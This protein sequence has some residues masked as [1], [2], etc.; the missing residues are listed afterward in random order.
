MSTLETLARPK[1]KLEDEESLPVDK[2]LK[3]EQLPAI[4]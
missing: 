4:F 3:I 1:R 2:S